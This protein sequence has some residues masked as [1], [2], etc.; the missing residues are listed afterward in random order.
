MG[1][2]QAYDM[3][4]CAGPIEGFIFIAWGVCHK[5]VIENAILSLFVDKVFRSRKAAEQDDLEGLKLAE[6]SAK[7]Y[8]SDMLAE[9]DLQK[10]DVADF[11]ELEEA[12]QVAS[13]K[14][15]LEAQGFDMKDFS[16]FFKMVSGL[17]HYEEITVDEF[18]DSILRVRGPATNMDL[19]A[20]KLQL[21]ALTN[22]VVARL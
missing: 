17:E 8:L 12:F 18:L 11:L 7:A 21:Q 10:D 13:V 16:S 3:I 15:W 22:L 9:Q 1:A 6:Q 19:Q 5:L 20:I 2:F 4:N 14:H